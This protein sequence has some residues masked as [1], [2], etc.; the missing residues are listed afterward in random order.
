MSSRKAPSC[1]A[2]GEGASGSG[3]GGK[4]VTDLEEGVKLLQVALLAQEWARGATNNKDPLHL[5]EELGL[6]N[7]P[8][9]K[10]RK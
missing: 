8:H 9:N 4:G 2:R 3:S 1:C 5:L 7:A 10:H 6:S